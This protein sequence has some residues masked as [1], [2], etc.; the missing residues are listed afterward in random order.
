[1][2]IE[3]FPQDIQP[4]LIPQ[5]SG[6]YV[7]QC[8][9]C[10]SQFS[11]ESLLYT[12]PECKNVLMIKDRNWDRLKSTS[13]PLWR[14]IFDYRAMLTIAP[15]KG[16]YRYHELI[17]SVIPLDSIVYLGEGHT[18]TVEAN[19][20]LCDWAGMQFSFKNDG[21]NPSA[22]FKDRGMASAFSYLNHI[23]KSQGLGEVLAICASTGDT[24][25][26]AALYASYMTHNVKSAVL[27]PHGKVTPQQLGQPLGSGAKVIEIPGVFDD[28][29]KIVEHLSENYPV[30]LMNSKNAWRILGQ[31]SFSY[32]IAQACDYDVT[33][34]VIVVPIGN[35]GNITAVLQGFLKLYDLQIITSLPVVV[36]VQSEHANPVYLYYLE[37]DPGKRKFRPVS[38]RAS[39][40]QA[41]MIGNPVSMPRVV[42]L[43]ERYRAIAGQSSVQ[44]VEVSE[45]QIMDAM[46]TANRNGHIACTQGGECL[47]GLRKC[48]ET[49]SLTGD[50]RAILD[51]TAHAL[52]FAVF[53]EKYFADDFEPEFGVVPREDL[54]NTPVLVVPSEGIPKPVSGGQLA[55]A[56][57]RLFVEDT[58]KQIA[59]LL[60]LSKIE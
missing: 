4:Y 29:M 48:V 55:A 53:Q 39:V 11:V 31:E 20:R 54:K 37:S 52:K 28:C 60:D 2:K 35:A 17:G 44:V 40:A 21:Q 7:Y 6:E 51:A 42:Q 45:Q 58:A 46:L 1:M 24:S 33:D 47:A 32:E 14:K 34:L 57:F 41:A 22:S 9:G 38:V 18:A 15:L 10:N 30:A 8:F 56:D 50:R 27:L 5:T 25:A 12:C 43:V 26:A 16:I 13:G 19:S 36:G 49:N 23:V 3:Q 59:H